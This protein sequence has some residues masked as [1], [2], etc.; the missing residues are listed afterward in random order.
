MYRNHIELNSQTLFVCSFLI[1]FSSA[2]L[3]IRVHVGTS[4]V[5]ISQVI[6]V[7]KRMRQ[8][9]NVHTHTHPHKQRQRH[10]LSAH[11]RKQKFA[12]KFQHF[13]FIF[14]QSLLLHIS[15]MWAK[16]ILEVFES[17]KLFTKKTFSN[18]SIG[19]AVAHNKK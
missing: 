2:L 14:D 3:F 15:R 16:L 19:N 18:V 5:V 4:F 9:R 17:I 13:L 1:I 11:L 8:F 7:V 10:S 6:L 12:A